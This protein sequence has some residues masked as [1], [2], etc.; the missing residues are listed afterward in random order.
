MSDQ[1]GNKKCCNV[2]IDQMIEHMTADLHASDGQYMQL[3][4]TPPA[5]TNEQTRAWNSPPGTHIFL[6]KLKNYHCIKRSL[7]QRFGHSY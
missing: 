4:F 1:T 3:G 7:L 6:N 2:T 5:T